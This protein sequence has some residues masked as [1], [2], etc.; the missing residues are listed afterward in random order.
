[1]S[2]EVRSFNVSSRGHCFIDLVDPANARDSGSPVLKVKCWSSRWRRIRTNLD[3]LGI[4]L[5]AGLVVRVKGEVEFYKPRG[6]ISFILSELDTDALLGKVAAERAR[7]IKAL[8]DED[9]FDRNKRLPVPY[10]PLRIGLV[11]S[12]GHRGLPRS[13]GQPRGIGHGLRHC[14][15]PDPGP[16]PS[17]GGLGGR[18]HPPS[19]VRATATCWSS[20]A[21]AVPRPT[22]PRSTPNRWPGPSP[23]RTPRCGRVSATP[24][25]SRWPTRWPIARSSPRPSAVRNWPGWSSSSG[26]T[27]STPGRSSPDWPPT[28]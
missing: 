3:Q 19:P 18:R 21:A 15:D 5:D 17:G 6:D 28:T 12:P 25:T 23:R 22:W 27:R 2:G 4:V 1:M 16:G 7:L 9:L 11:A 10:L 14:G 26:G 8:V 13:A 24:V 20:S